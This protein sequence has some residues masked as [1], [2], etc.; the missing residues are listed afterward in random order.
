M[1]MPPV[2]LEFTDEMRAAWD[3]LGRDNVFVTGRAGTGKSTLLTQF[4][5]TTNKRVVK[6]APTGGAAL[7]IGGSTLHSFFGFKPGIQPSK[8]AA[9]D[10]KNP[11]LYRSLDALIID[12]SSMVRAD[13]LD[14]VDACL[15]VHGPY[16]GEHFGGFCCK[17]RRGMGGGLLELWTRRVRQP[18]RTRC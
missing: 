5:S 1:M 11:E 4:C 8:A 16:P 18:G 12:E 7:N 13:H 10:I 17:N 2:D 15:R 9:A 6:L 14:C 3:R